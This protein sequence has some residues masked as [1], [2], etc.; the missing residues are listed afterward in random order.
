VL[1]Y[2]SVSYS[3]RYSGE[4]SVSNPPYYTSCFL[5]LQNEIDQ[6]FIKSV[7]PDMELVKL[8]NL[9]Y[10]PYPSVVKDFFVEFAAYGFPILFVFCMIFSAKVLIKVR[11]MIF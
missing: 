7:K 1:Y 8:E 2:I 9:R 5:M 3:R 4:N 10:F 11:I 6:A